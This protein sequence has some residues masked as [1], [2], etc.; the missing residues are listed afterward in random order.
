MEITAAVSRVGVEILQS[1]I[2][3]DLDAEYNRII[4]NW[5]MAHLTIPLDYKNETKNNQY[6]KNEELKWH[7]LQ[8]QSQL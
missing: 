6:R 4:D 5:E 2:L 7:F 8:Q 3:P 1:K